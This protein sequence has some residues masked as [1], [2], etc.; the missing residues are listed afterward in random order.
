M[1]TKTILLIDLTIVTVWTIFCYWVR[2]TYFLGSFIII[3]LLVLLRLWMSFSLYRREKR[4][5]WLVGAMV[6]I[7][8]LGFYGDPDIMRDVLFLPFAKCW[9][10]AV[11][12]ITEQNN[13]DVGLYHYLA[14]RYGVD[15]VKT[16]VTWQYVV[17]ALLTLWLVLAP[18]VWCVVL[19]C[20]RKLAARKWSWQPSAA[21]KDY[22]ACVAL[23]VITLVCGLFGYPKFSVVATL[24]LPILF[25]CYFFCPWKENKWSLVVGACFV[26]G[27][28]SLVIFLST[29][30]AGFARWL[31]LL[32]GLCLVAVA[33]VACARVT[34][35]R[36]E[37]VGA[38]VACGVLFPVLSLGFNPFAVTGSKVCAAF[39]AY[40]YS[41][42]G[43][44]LVEKD[45]GKT[46][47]RDRYGLILEPK[48]EQIAIMD[49]SKPYVRLLQD[50]KWGIYD[51]ERHE[52]V[53][54]PVYESIT[55]YPD[56]TSEE[57]RK[58]RLTSVW[59][60]HKRSENG[61]MEWDEYF[62]VGDYYIRSDRDCGYISNSPVC[63]L[64]DREL[65]LD[66]SEEM[67]HAAEMDELLD[68]MMRTLGEKS[69]RTTYADF[70]WVWAALLTA[71]IDELY[72]REGMF[73][74][75]DTT[76]YDMAM[77][78]IEEYVSPSAGGTQMEMND[79]AYVHAVVELYRTLKANLDLAA[80]FPEA[81]V[82]REWTLFDE[83]AKAMED[84][85]AQ[86]DEAEKGFCSDKP[87]EDYEE[88]ALRFHA[89]KQSLRDIMAAAG[90]K[91]IALLAEPVSDETLRS[92]FH[93]MM[94]GVMRPVDHEGEY[95]TD[96]IGQY[97]FRWI[98]FRD[99]LASQLP[100]D[101]ARSYRNQTQ[102]I[103]SLLM[104]ASVD[105]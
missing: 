50:G 97:V 100:Q 85:Q 32:G 24:V 17:P 104:S 66:Y 90:G 58:K 35:R 75:N 33:S 62:K 65:A 93:E 10:V 47:L 71:E 25:A 67:P 11:A 16:P 51:L 95:L 22:L 27:F 18:V 49:A 96:T 79:H 12:T 83:Y 43:L 55:R 63:H 102:N 26:A 21:L 72:G 73:H 76:R 82:R 31:C 29:Y 101:V 81:D 36:K 53:V 57:L 98:A 1:R 41:Y 74:S 37:A 61:D 54:E 28:G 103:R 7:V 40:D 44:Y 78:A 59:V 38:A 99:T 19:L 68:N 91:T 13:R 42:R 64:L 20:G 2:S 77:D 5:L 4:G 6:V 8:A 92:R 14:E 60:L 87:R 45:S 52:M 89:R 39:D 34:G 70:Y 80:M 48:Y 56:I 30:C 23:T 105:D 3:L 84:F 86:V 15:Y 9:D 69:E 88:A 46:G 94:P